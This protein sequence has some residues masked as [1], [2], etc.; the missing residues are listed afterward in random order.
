MVQGSPRKI[1]GVDLHGCGLP[2]FEIGLDFETKVA[3]HDPT[4]A[5]AS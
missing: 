1:Q 5:L 4:L 2:Y 3:F